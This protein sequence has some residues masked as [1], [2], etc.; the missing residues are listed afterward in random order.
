EIDSVNQQL[1]LIVINVDNYN[2]IHEA[3]DELKDG[4]ILKFPSASYSYDSEVVIEGIKDLFI[5]ASNTVF[6]DE[7]R[8][9][10]TST[11]ATGKTNAGFTVKNCPNFSFN[12]LEFTSTNVGSPE[13]NNE[14]SP[15]PIF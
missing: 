14:D 15:T 1:A 10:Q 3:I 6:I 7:G 2:S 12:S 4:S 5:D 13:I 9:I 8:E 11:G